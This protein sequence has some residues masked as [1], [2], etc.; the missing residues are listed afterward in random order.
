MSWLKFCHFL[1]NVHNIFML[2]FVSSHLSQSS[3]MMFEESC[4]VVWKMV[5]PLS[6][7]RCCS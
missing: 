7:V 2:I 6:L 3:L 4:V 1:L 5:S